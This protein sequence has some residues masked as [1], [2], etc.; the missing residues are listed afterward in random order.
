MHVKQVVT[1]KMLCLGPGYWR[2][3]TSKKPWLLLVQ[4]T[5]VMITRVHPVHGHGIHDG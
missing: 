1:L 2:G 4:V 5:K 3:R